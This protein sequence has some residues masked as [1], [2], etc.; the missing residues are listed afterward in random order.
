M[1]SLT[2]EEPKN[3]FP[4]RRDAGLYLI[5]LGGFWGCCA[6]AL[7]AADAVAPSFVVVVFFVVAGICGFLHM[8]TTRRFEGRI[9]GRSVRPWPFGYASLRTQVIATLPS[10]VMAAA[11][12]LKWHAVML[13]VAIYSLLIV[14]LVALVAWPTNR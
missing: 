8:N 7:I 6:A 2:V 1:K 3:L 9:S 13:T 12:R 11:Q 10:T 14:G 5:G 4:T